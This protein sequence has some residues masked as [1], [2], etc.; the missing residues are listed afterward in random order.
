MIIVFNGLSISAYTFYWCN[1]AVFAHLR[2]C[3]RNYSGISATR[4]YGFHWINQSCSY[5][6]CYLYFSLFTEVTF[7]GV[8]CTFD[9]FISQLVEFYGS[10]LLT[11]IKNAIEHGTL[12]AAVLFCAFARNRYQQWR[13]TCE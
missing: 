10:I 1:V 7:F 13:K 9:T 3:N 11:I 4:V 12:V 2:C 8:T 6:R 5:W